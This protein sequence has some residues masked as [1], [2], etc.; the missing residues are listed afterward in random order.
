VR[1]IVALPA[2]QRPPGCPEALAGLLNLAGVAIPVLRLD[3]LLGLPASPPGAYQA[4]IILRD[5]EPPLAVLADRAT[6]VVA[7][8]AARIL[9]VAPEETYNGCVSAQLALDDGTTA[10]LLSCERVV[11]ERERRSLADF[12]AMQQRRLDELGL[13]IQE[14]S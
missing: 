13:D 10:H 12:Q 7:V 4:V 11:D 14:A 2:L 5:A 9:P 6:D 3:R 1:E 8:S